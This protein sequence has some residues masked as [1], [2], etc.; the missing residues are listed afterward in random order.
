MPDYLLPANASDLEIAL[1]QA[2]GRVGDVPVRLRHLWTP[3]E[4]VPD[5]LPWLAWTMSVDEWS[6]AWPTEV[7]RQAVADS[8]HVHSIKGTPGAIKR[9]LRSIGYGGADIVEGFPPL[10]RD[11]GIYRDG[12]SSYAG[13]HRWAL[14]DVVLD[15]GEWRAFDG[16]DQR[17]VKR[18]I[19]LWKNARSHLR[20][21]SA[22][23]RLNSARGTEDTPTSA[24]AWRAGLV[25]SSSPGPRDGRVLRGHAGVRYR[26]D[27]AWTYDDTPPR[28]GRLFGAQAP[29]TFGAER[30]PVTL[31]PALVLSSQRMRAIRYDWRTRRGQDLPRGHVDAFEIAATR[32]AWALADTARGDL[33]HNGGRPYAAPIYRG[34]PGAARDARRDTVTRFGTDAFKRAIKRPAPGAFRDGTWRFGG[35]GAPAPPPPSPPAADART[36][37]FRMVSQTGPVPRDGA[38]LYTD[39]AGAWRSPRRA[40]SAAAR[41]VVITQARRGTPGLTREPTL[42]HDGA[43]PRTGAAR[44]TR[45]LRY[46]PLRWVPDEEAA[47]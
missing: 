33:L 17:A 10:S 15:L 28:D 41:L 39:G 18:Q 37:V 26:H 16:N 46:G 35:D 43:T 6:D 14:F 23:L 27:A 4:I 11:E 9:G 31:V 32:I 44:R 1:D 20:S 38:R 24:F 29:M 47:S 45:I 3:D 19:E 22:V 40:P 36:A 5:L 7:K 12:Q 25:L 21:V 2:A 13:T 42:R 30:A 34:R 8:H